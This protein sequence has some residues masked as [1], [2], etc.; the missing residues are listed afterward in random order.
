MRISKQDARHIIDF[1]SLRQTYS[2]DC[3]ANAVQTILTYYGIDMQESKIMEAMGTDPDEGTN[4]KKIVEFFNSKGLKVDVRKGMTLGILKKVIQL[5]LPVMMPIQAYR[6]DPKTK[7]KEDW[8]D[9]HYVVAIGFTDTSVIFCDP[10]SVEDT[11]LTFSELEDRW[12]DEAPGSKEKLDHF[13]MI[14]Y[15]KQPFYHEDD[16]IHM[17]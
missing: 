7:Y 16:V 14:I 17:D 1:P 4:Y 12:H 11:F 9:G 6:D 10:S 8:D 2:Y 15:G 3:G 13:G 5:G